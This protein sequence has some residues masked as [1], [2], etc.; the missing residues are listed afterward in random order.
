MKNVVNRVLYF[1]FLAVLLTATVLLFVVST[2]NRAPDVED[3]QVIAGADRLVCVDPPDA[4]RAYDSLM[5]VNKNHALNA[6]FMPTDLDEVMP[7]AFAYPEGFGVSR[8]DIQLQPPVIRALAALIEALDGQG[9]ADI[10]V[11]SGYRDF[12][13][14]V[15]LQERRTVRVTDN[16]VELTDVALPGQSEHQLGLAVDMQT[17]LD[18]R[19]KEFFHQTQP[20][21]WIGTYG[22]HFGF[23]MRYPKK[24]EETTGIMFEP[25]HYRYVGFPHAAVMKQKDLCLEDYLEFLREAKTVDVQHDKLYKYQIIYYAPGETVLVPRD[26]AYVYSRDN[27]GGTVVTVDFDVEKQYHELWPMLPVL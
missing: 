18:A 15:E 13:A 1:V 26:Y 5:L 25:W 21:M 24:D 19:S 11:I 7:L 8:S 23:V 9:R 16:G 20:G 3:M 22:H 2:K 10:L 14:Q 27:M 12:Y 4:G 17:Q 6:A